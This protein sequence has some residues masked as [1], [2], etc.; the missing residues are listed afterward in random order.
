ILLG[1]SGLL[2]EFVV[3]NDMNRIPRD[4]VSSNKI[5]LFGKK[6]F[7]F[8]TENDLIYHYDKQLDYHTNGLTFELVDTSEKVLCEETYFS[9]GGGFIVCATDIQQGNLL[10]SKVDVPYSFHTARQLLSYCK[11][12]NKNISDI[13]LANERARCT[14][15]EIDQK[16]ERIWRVMDNC[17][18]RGLKTTGIL[19]G[20]L[21]VT[22][23]APLLHQ[24]LL[25]HKQS[26]NTENL[27][28]AWLNV[29]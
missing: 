17:I 28:M 6:A 24:K 22:R 18:E 16:I 20:G 3:E 11:E 9:V 12:E 23:R 29:F 7:A 13:V 21:E 25:S 26:G 15:E 2:P 5:N 8:D 4:V 1:L 19:P 14:D 27:M 10:Q